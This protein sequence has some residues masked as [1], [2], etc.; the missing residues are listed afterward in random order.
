[1]AAVFALLL[2]YLVLRHLRKRRQEPPGF[3]PEALKRR[4][5]TWSPGTNTDPA[6]TARSPPTRP[7]RQTRRLQRGTSS[8]NGGGGGGGGGNGGG[9]VGGGG[10]EVNRNTSVRS[11]M[12]L[13]EYRPVALADRERTIAREGER[14]GIDVVIEF[15][16]T[17]DEEEERREEHMQTLYEIR[18]ARQ[19]ERAT[20]RESSD[21]AAAAQQADSSRNSNGY[22]NG[23]S[24]IRAVP[25]EPA[26]TA[27]ALMA[28]LASITERERRISKVQYAEVGVARHDGTRVRPSMDSDRPLIDSSAPM[29]TS[30]GSVR[31]NCPGHGR[32]GSGLS[33][34]SG[35]GDTG[36]PE[37]RGS[38]EIIR[39]GS[40]R[41]STETHRSRDATRPRSQERL[42]GPPP[43]S[44][45]RQPP[46]PDY[47]GDEWG[48]PPG[49][50]SSAESA[51]AGVNGLPILRIDTG[52]P[53]PGV[54]RSATPQPLEQRL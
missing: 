45:D 17:V 42:L 48:P 24:T 53:S 26:A 11:V 54:S 43:C 37:R 8:A 31:S 52:T 47:D 49:Y 51:N 2:F 39:M 19:L 20:T 36:S 44:D 34:A 16:E 40:R 46:A 25:A 15:P 3:L 35:G 41:P 6:S 29:G 30:G 12:T 4:W 33:M 13:P 28:A 21:I 9:G 1:M 5:R 32:T 50:S 10:V 14:G 27:A 22:G 38:D 18:L 23:N 7:A